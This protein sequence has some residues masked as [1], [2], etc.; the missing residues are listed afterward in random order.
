MSDPKSLPA[1]HSNEL[2]S[3]AE[4]QRLLGRISEVYATGQV[5]AHQAV[6]VQMTEPTG[7]LAETLLSSSRAARFVPITARHFF[8]P[9]TAT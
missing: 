6:N 2:T 5:R 1:T 8:P 4:Y 3:D 7:R 9:S